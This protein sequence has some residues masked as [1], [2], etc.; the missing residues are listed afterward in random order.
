MSKGTYK[1]EALDGSQIGS[2]RATKPSTDSTE[3]SPVRVQELRLPGVTLGVSYANSINLS[4]ER[5]KELQCDVTSAWKVIQE[6]TLDFESAKRVFGVIQNMVNMKVVDG[7]SMAENVD[8]FDFLNVIKR[9]TTVVHT[10]NEQIE[11]IQTKLAEMETAALLR[12]IAINVEYEKKLKCWELMTSDTQNKYKNRKT[13]CLDKST[14][15]STSLSTFENDVMVAKWEEYLQFYNAKEFFHTTA[16]YKRTAVIED[17][18]SQ[19]KKGNLM[20]AH[21]TKIDCKGATYDNCVQL[22]L[23]STLG[24]KEKTEVVIQLAQ[25]KAIRKKNRHTDFLYA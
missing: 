10:Q 23:R 8:I 19:L 3:T 24:E 22:V 17:A 9:L 16:T 2:A 21:P 18:I 20:F 7:Q 15:K 6:N 4:A 11:R 5:M 14:V 1:A 12:Q 13:G 25:L